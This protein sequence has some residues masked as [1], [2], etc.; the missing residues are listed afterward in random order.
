MN[1]IRTTNIDRRFQL[2]VNYSCYTTKPLSK[3]CTI[4]VFFDIFFNSKEQSMCQWVRNFM[5]HVAIDVSV[6]DGDKSLIEVDS[7]FFIS[8]L[9]VL[10]SSFLT[11]ISFFSPTKC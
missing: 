8:S 10:K 9:H 3:Y 2:P 7:G 6:S 1:R 5:K 4:G 11:D